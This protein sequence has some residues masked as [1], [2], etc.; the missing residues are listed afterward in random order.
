MIKHPL[1]ERYFPEYPQHKLQALAD[2]IQENKQKLPI[3]TYQGEQILDGWNRWRAMRLLGWTKA[4]MKF[5]VFPGTPEE[6]LAFVFSLNY[7]RRHQSSTDLETMMQLLLATRHAEPATIGR[8]PKDKPQVT[9]QDMAEAAGVSKS[10]IKR[11]KRGK[12]QIGKPD[13]RSDDPLSDPFGHVIPPAALLYWNRRNEVEAIV[14]QTKQLAHRI[15]KLSKDD[16]MWSKLS[17]QALEAKVNAVA[18]DFSESMPYCICVSCLGI[19]PEN[20][21]L[22]DK[23]GLITKYTYDTAVPQEMKNETT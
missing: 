9:L 4:Q 7:H 3:I 13:K 23:R 11:R 19:D 16:P 14:G 10:T 21:R 6:A 20:C 5:V 8:P 15:K 22:C 17:L 18:H 2:D 1:V 12:R